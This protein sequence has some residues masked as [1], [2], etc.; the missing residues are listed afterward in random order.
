MSGDFSVQNHR[1]TASKLNRY[2]GN[3]ITIGVGGL[4]I[5]IAGKAA[6]IFCPK[7]SLA[8]SIF[9]TGS[10]L[11]IFAGVLGFAVAGGA[12]FL[13]DSV[14]DADISKQKLKLDTNSIK[15]KVKQLKNVITDQNTL[16]D[17]SK[18]SY[19]INYA[20]LI[21]LQI[22]KDIQQ[23]IYQALGWKN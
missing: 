21:Y 23:S 1:D 19:Y 6:S 22:K 11:S 9:S 7:G 17:E 3:G 8:K 16:I 12:C 5:G 10:S 18:L 2:A 13:I 15:S 20:Q 4:T 14:T